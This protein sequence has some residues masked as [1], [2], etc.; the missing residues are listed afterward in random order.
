[1]NF[2]RAPF[3]L[4]AT[5]PLAASVVV[6]A[7]ADVGK[8]VWLM[9]LSLICGAC[10]LAVAGQF[11][12]HRNHRF[13]P[14]NGI[15]LLTLIGLAAPLFINS[16]GPH[17]WVRFGPL[18]LYMAPLLLPS[19]YA[20]CS[21]FLQKRGK[22]EPIAFAALVGAS[23]LLAM[24][25]DASQVLALLAGS[26][27]LLW[28]Y[29]SDLFRPAVT[30]ATIALV[31]A[32]TFTRPDLLEPVPHVEGVFAL[33][34]GASLLAGL[35]VIG[36]AFIFVAGL[37]ACSRRGAVWLAAAAAYYAVLFLCSVAGLT[38]APL[39]GYG[40]GPLLGFGLLAAVSGWVDPEALPGS[41]VKPTLLRSAV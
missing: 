20:A 27:V 40:A 13:T 15:A 8:S 26:A 17:R 19:F 28:R 18:S 24:Q 36:S 5:F 22:Q 41:S 37:Y 2:V 35:A 16:S 29:C 1:M 33:A 6:L 32:W 21:A 30:L 25:P 23:L 14:A 3:L 4:T 38:P 9:H 11:L 39:I 10:L 34:L 31:A 12:N 7:F